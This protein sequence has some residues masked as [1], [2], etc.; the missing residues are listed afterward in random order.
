[1]QFLQLRDSCTIT[2]S[3][4]ATS[5][6]H[7]WWNFSFSVMF[8]LLDLKVN[9]SFISSTLHWMPWFGRDNKIVASAAPREDTEPTSFQET[10]LTGIDLPAKTTVYKE[11]NDLEAKQS[12]EIRSHCL[13]V[14]AVLKDWERGQGGII[15]FREAQL[16]IYYHQFILTSYLNFK[17]FFQCWF[18]ISYLGNSSQII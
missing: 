9:S 4:W 3:P 11:K 2:K 18:C 15:K 16:N 17:I 12:Q 7:L 10:V 1:M 6:M 5:L 8:S 14:D 13:N